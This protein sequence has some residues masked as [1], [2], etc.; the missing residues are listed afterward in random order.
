MRTGLDEFSQKKCCV[1]LTEV[2]MLRLP[3]QTVEEEVRR[4]GE[5]GLLQWVGYVRIGNSS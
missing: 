1:M 5:V 2:E 4:P 3:E